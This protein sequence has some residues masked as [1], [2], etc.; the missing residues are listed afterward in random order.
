MG[1]LHGTR[2]YL[3][4]PV[5]HDPDASQWRITITEVLK[6]MEIGS[7]DPLVK[8]DWLHDFAHADPPYY[9]RGLAEGGPLLDRTYEAMTDIRRVCMAQVAASDFMICHLPKR[10]TFGTIMELKLFDEMDKPVFIHSP[11]GIPSTWAFHQ[12]SDPKT[13]KDVFYPD[14]ESLIEKLKLIDTGTIELDPFQWISISYF[15]PDVA[16]WQ[17]NVSSNQ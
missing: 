10:F 6:T 17:K 15:K 12:F 1:I 16:R 11:D 3:A 9:Y 5:D 2:C 7:F 8:P 4:G 13:M 14:W